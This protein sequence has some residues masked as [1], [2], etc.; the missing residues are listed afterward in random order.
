M[1]GTI[2]LGGLLVQGVI[3][4]INATVE[5]ARRAE[6]NR[7]RRIANKV[8]NIHY[9]HHFLSSTIGNDSRRIIAEVTAKSKEYGIP[10]SEN[11]SLLADRISQICNDVAGIYISDIS[12]ITSESRLD[13]VLAELNKADIEAGRITAVLDSVENKLNRDIQLRLTKIKHLQENINLHSKK[14]DDII[15]STGVS[16]ERI[17][18]NLK[19]YEISCDSR[20][21][22]LQKELQNCTDSYQKDSNEYRQ[23]NGN[24]TEETVQKL[25]ELDKRFTAV[26]QKIRNLPAVATTIA[27]DLRQKYITRLDDEISALREEIA[28]QER[29]AAVKKAEEE[30]RQ[31]AEQQEKEA[32]EVAEKLAKAEQIKNDAEKKFQE[33]LK[34]PY[35]P[36]KCKEEVVTLRG[37]LKAQIEGKFIVECNLSD[38]Y[39]ISILPEIK[40][41]S[42]R[43]KANEELV[44]R[45]NNALISYQYLCE[46]TNTDMKEFP[47]T[48]SGISLM[49]V[50]TAELHD[51]AVKQ[52]EERYIRQSIDEVMEE[53]GINF[54][55]HGKEDNGVSKS[56]LYR[57]ND[58]TAVG[59]TVNS[60]GEIAMEVGGMDTT[61]REPT[62]QEATKLEKDMSSFC[63][64]YKK[65]REKLE[66]K[67]IRMVTNYELPPVSEYSLI[68][69][70]R[71]YD[72]DER[73]IEQIMME[74]QNEELQTARQE[75]K[76]Y[77]DS[78]ED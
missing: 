63:Q 50:A 9:K 57:F 1:S 45:Y 71:D 18:E 7:R 39:A 21:D 8:S 49:E 12:N 64:R 36:D 13:D 40:K 27:D 67:G 78:Q 66:E 46:T 24:C 5:A 75:R 54:I 17:K 55:G 29:L 51:L 70:L 15:H 6:E 19:K 47:V 34:N 30:K 33:I 10:V 76:M 16:V 69:N 74:Q 68:H 65:I 41:I 25:T 31:L 73:T 26:Y 38:F 22:D 61:D 60:T 77:I 44:T 48:D 11:L 28:E 42:A 62:A 35:A 56:T 14:I 2:G 43:V 20:F 59:V 32:R 3:V 37:K 52:S 58:S 4:G 53:L 23:N 72:I